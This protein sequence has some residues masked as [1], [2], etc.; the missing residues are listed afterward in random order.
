MQVINQWTPTE[1]TVEEEAMVA[2]GEAMEVAEVTSRGH[3][4]SHRLELEPRLA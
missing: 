4:A 1:A 3:K 2:V